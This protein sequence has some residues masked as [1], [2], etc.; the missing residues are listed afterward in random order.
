MNLF[1]LPQWERA[2]VRAEPVCAALTFS[3]LPPEEGEEAFA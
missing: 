2:R 1:P 3:P